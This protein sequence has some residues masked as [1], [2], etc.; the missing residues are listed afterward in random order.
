[1]LPPDVT[2]LDIHRPSGRNAARLKFLAAG[3][4][5]RFMDEMKGSSLAC[6][7]LGAVSILFHSPTHQ[8]R[9]LSVV[10]AIEGR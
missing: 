2:G 3:E 5:G 7:R 6:S 9:V 1:M 8:C 4:V 10:C